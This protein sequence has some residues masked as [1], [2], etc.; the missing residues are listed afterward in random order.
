MENIMYNKKDAEKSNRIKITAKFLADGSIRLRSIENALSMEEIEKLQYG[1]EI[2]RIYKSSGE[3]FVQFSS[4]KPTIMLY[5]SCYGGRIDIPFNG[6]VRMEK[7]DF[8]KLVNVMRNIGKSFS[9][10]KHS[11]IKNMESNTTFEVII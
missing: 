9:M 1:N 6:S 11:V 10:I 2:A 8:D 4:D 5:S 3:Y 7:E